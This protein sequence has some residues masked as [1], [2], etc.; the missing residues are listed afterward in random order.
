MPQADDIAQKLRVSGAEDKFP[1]CMGEYAKVGDHNDRPLYRNGEMHIFFWAQDGNWLI[2]KSTLQPVDSF[3]TSPAGEL[4]KLPERA[5]QWY[6]LGEGKWDPAPNVIIAR[7]EEVGELKIKALFDKLDDGDGFLSLKEFNEYMAFTSFDPDPVK[8][9]TS[10]QYLRYM[11]SN[12]PQNQAP[13]RGIPFAVFVKGYTAHPMG[14]EM[15]AHHMQKVK[16]FQ[17]LWDVL[18]DDE[19]DAVS[20]LELTKLHHSMKETPAEA[21]KR[22]DRDGNGALSKIESAQFLIKMFAEGLRQPGKKSEL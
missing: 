11:R 12:D 3:L 19:D 9:T 20:V 21:V 8:E 18:D 7:V 10:D 4:A 13:A 16:I 6:T 15:L 22:L 2:G 17:K 14:G 1:A 5:S